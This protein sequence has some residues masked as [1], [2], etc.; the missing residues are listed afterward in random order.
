MLSCAW[1]IEAAPWQIESQRNTSSHARW[2]LRRI[3]LVDKAGQMS[4]QGEDATMPQR[5]SIVVTCK[6]RL[7]Y[8][9]QS[10]PRFLAQ[11]ATEVVVVDY[12]C[13]ENTAATVNERHPEAVVVRVPDVA[14][15]HL[16]DARNIGARAATGDVLIFLDADIVIPADFVTRIDTRIRDDVFFR[17]PL[18]EEIRGRSG[19]CIVWKRHFE[20]VEGYDDLIRGYGGDDL[21]LYYRLSRIG[22]EELPLDEGYIE[23]IVPHDPDTRTTFYKAKSIA[24]NVATNFA[25]LQMKF[26]AMRF[27]N[28]SNLRR[29]VLEKLYAVAQERVAA[30]PEEDGNSIKFEIKL[31]EEEAL[32]LLKHWK[33]SR[34][35]VI[36]MERAKSE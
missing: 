14:E 19:S 32:P 8:L 21:D 17:F 28:R 23:S 9:L 2:R 1:R 12:N 22:L 26:A 6:G 3:D 10:L 13:P 36:R 31:R 33:V 4:G 16:A 35:L 5:Y 27:Y 15:F 34:S 18:S 7:R 25:Y 20:Q 29:E 11:P 24:D 30:T